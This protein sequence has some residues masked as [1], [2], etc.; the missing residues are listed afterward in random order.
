MVWNIDAKTQMTDNSE[1]LGLLAIAH[2][3][4][5]LRATWVYPSLNNEG[6]VG[7]DHSVV[8]E[9]RRA[10]QQARTNR[11][12]AVSATTRVHVPGRGDEKGMVIYTPIFRS[13]T[14][15]GFI[16]A[17]YGYREFFS[18]ITGSRLSLS[19]YHAAISIGGE[20]VFATPA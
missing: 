15:A 5:N 19:D 11:S 9:R 20:Q 12:P 7:M 4:P 10:L 1:Q 16:A 18:A 17:E 2:L 6:A 3:D 13:G 8:E 14:L